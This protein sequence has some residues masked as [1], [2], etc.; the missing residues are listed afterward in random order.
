MRAINYIRIEMG[1]CEKGGNHKLVPATNTKN[2]GKRKCRKCDLL[3]E[4][5]KKI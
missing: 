4:N 3:E 5:I 1:S 2:I